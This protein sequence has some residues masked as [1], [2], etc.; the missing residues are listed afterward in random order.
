MSS[1]KTVNTLPYYSC[2]LDGQEDGQPAYFE[3][4]DAVEATRTVRES[5][6][7]AAAAASSTVSITVLPLTG[8]GNTGHCM[9]RPE[10]HRVAADQRQS[11]DKVQQPEVETTPEPETDR[12]SADG[13]ENR[14]LDLAN[15]A[16]RGASAPVVRVSDKETPCRPRSDITPATTQPEV[17]IRRPLAALDRKSTCQEPRS[18]RFDRVVQYFDSR[19]HMSGKTGHQTVSFRFLK[20]FLRRILIIIIVGIIVI[21]LSSS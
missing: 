3:H 21:I 1:C 19:Q 12:L 9:Y 17:V 20:Q 2:S 6:E 15:E 13:V 10:A 4:A 14:S 16:F 7:R 18:E 5:A 8:S 11:N